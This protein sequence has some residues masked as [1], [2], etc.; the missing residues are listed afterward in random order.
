M[1]SNGRKQ[2]LSAVILVSLA[3]AGCRPDAMEVKN[4]TLPAAKPENTGWIITNT[5]GHDAAFTLDING[6]FW[7]TADKIAAQLQKQS[8]DSLAFVLNSLALVHSLSRNAPP[9]STERWMHNPEVLLNSLGQGFCDDRAAALCRI[10]QAGGLEARIWHLEGHTVPE[11][12]LGGRWQLFDPD[13]GVYY[14]NGDSAVCSVEAIARGEARYFSMR[15]TLY[16]ITPEKSVLL[17]LDKYLSRDDNRLSEWYL[18]GPAAPD[19]TFR[20]PSGSSLACC[21][22]AADG[23]ANGSYASVL[24]PPHT[25]GALYIPLVLAARP[26][27]MEAVFP[28]ADTLYGET[29]VQ[30]PTADTLALRYFVNPFLP[31]LQQQNHFT[32]RGQGAG[33]LDIALFSQEEALPATPFYFDQL[34]EQLLCSDALQRFVH[35]ILPRLPA[36]NDMDELP[37]FFHAYLQQKGTAPDE[38]T[39]RE[40]AFQQRFLVARE[41]LQKQPGMEAHIIH[42]PVFLLLAMEYFGKDIGLDELAAFLESLSL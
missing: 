21:Q 23:W 11:V 17:L 12:K 34:R 38:I 40:A 36:I 31:G 14:T 13:V 1:P 22:P 41:V 7:L 15:D 29:L 18:S 33:Q 8:P 35:D 37:A 26:E 25:S 10:W 6:T 9:M 30:N 16:A 5:G 27:G 3:L 19:T 42:T 39:R 20:L 28:F 32:L 4:A 24:L 2:A